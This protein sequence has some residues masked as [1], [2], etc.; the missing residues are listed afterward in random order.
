V[1]ALRAAVDAM[2]EWRPV[3]RVEGSRLLVVGDTHGYVE[4]TR[5]ALARAREL[6]VDVVVFLG[7]LVDRGPCGVENLELLAGAVVEGRPRVVLV[8]GDHE[9]LVLN[10]YY[11]FRDELRS[12]VGADAEGVVGEFYSLMPLAAVAGPVFLVHG[13]IPCRRCVLDE[14]PPYTVG[15]IED[16][17]REEL[18]GDPEAR[19]LGYGRVSLQLMWNDPRGTI[20]WF[21]PSARGQ[22]IF[23]YGREAWRAFLEANGFKVIVRAHEVTDGFHVWRPDGSQVQGLDASPL[24]IEE[25]SGSVVTVFSSLYH[26]MRAGALLV[27]LERGVLVPIYYEEAGGEVEGGGDADPGPGG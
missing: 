3:E 13:G 17:V 27:D 12:K 25:L 18:G 9:S 2:G 21:L 22:G 24:G 10:T 23:Y 20:D 16:A 15:E 1:E 6:G 14:E 8:R 7:D 5:W 4:V 19:S 26:G 11:G